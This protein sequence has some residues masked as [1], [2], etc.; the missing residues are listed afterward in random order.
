MKFLKLFQHSLLL[1]L[2]LGVAIITVGYL[3]TM[4]YFQ[5]QDLNNSI[6]SIANANETQFELKQFLSD[7][8]NN[9]SKLKS[10]IIT[11]DSS[12]YK[13]H[14]VYKSELENHFSKLILLGKEN[15]NIL[16]QSDSLKNLIEKRFDLY[17]QVQQLVSKNNY[18]HSELNKKLL[19]SEKYN[20]YLQSYIKKLIDTEDLK[21]RNQQEKHEKGIRQSIQTALILALLS[22]IIFFISYT[23]TNSGIIKLKK[24]NDDLT[25]LNET[26]NN[27]EKIANFGHWKINTVTNKYTLSDNYF[28]LM[29]YEPNSFELTV[30]NLITNIHPEDLAFVMKKHADSLADHQPTS[31]VFRVILKNNK[32]RYIKSVGSFRKNTKGE[33]VKIGV[34]YDISEQYNNNLRLTENNQKLIDINAELESFNNIVSHDLQEPLRKIQMFISRLEDNDI[35]NLSNQG[36][37]YFNKIRFSANR[38]QNLMMD[39]VNY[40]KAIKGDKILVKTDLNKLLSNVVEELSI[41]IEE[42]KAIISIGKLPVINLIPFQIQQLFVNLISNSLKYSKENIKPEINIFEEEITESVFQEG[43]IINKNNFYKIV[44]SDNGIGFDQVFA[45]SIF[46]LF[47]RLETEKTYNG[48]GLGLAICKKII[49]NHNGFIKAYGEPDIGSKFLIY[50]PKAV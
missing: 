43:K 41:N 50:L 20:D 2:A 6:K 33:L 9:E 17:L 34:N 3:T 42:K 19:E 21:V 27:A 37:D 5:M 1:K 26:F 15:S 48:T 12:Y 4:F 31:I 28:R 14:F 49:E 18:N 7:V 38:M 11:R 10:F 24:A 40:A 32:I 35:Q 39:L 8:N 45:E 13:N 30:E 47:K 25:F 44:I 46:I 29:G 22:I 23:R 36:K 16:N